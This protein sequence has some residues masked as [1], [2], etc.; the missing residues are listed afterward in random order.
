MK[1]MEMTEGI[2]DMTSRIKTTDALDEFISIANEF[3]GETS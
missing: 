1:G 3:L 2:I